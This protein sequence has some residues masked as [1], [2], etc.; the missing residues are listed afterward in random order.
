MV[1]SAILLNSKS[2]VFLARFSKWQNMWAI[3][4]GKVK[5]G[6][7]LLKGLRRELKEETSLEIDTAELFRVSESVCDS[8]FHDGSWHMVFLDYVVR[9]YRG[10]PRLD[11]HELT[12]F[13][14]VPLSHAVNLEL[15]PATRASLKCLLE[16]I[17]AK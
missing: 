16:K 8:T 9:S 11:K 17:N 7:T 13:R 4:G 1:V 6:E 14:W 3:P 5:Y 2:E 10:E 15:T 12:E